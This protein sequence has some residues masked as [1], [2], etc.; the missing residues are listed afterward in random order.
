M[1]F[2]RGLQIALTAI[3][4]VSENER[5]R[6]W[7]AN[8]TEEALVTKPYYW[9]LSADV[10]VSIGA[11][12]KGVSTSARSATGFRRRPNNISTLP[13]ANDGR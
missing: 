10:C 11:D 2:D 5:L 7:S 9:F 3:Q 12:V 6:R 8:V 1:N 4:D 13:F